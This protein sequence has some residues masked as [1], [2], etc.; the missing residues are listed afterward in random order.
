M[1]IILVGILTYNG[2]KKTV[3]K[4]DIGMETGFHAVV[5][6]NSYLCTS[7]L[8]IGMRKLNLSGRFFFQV[9]VRKKHKN[10]KPA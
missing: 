4:A 6:Y 5:V 8:N 2:V 7:V 9:L 3:S 1:K 10:K